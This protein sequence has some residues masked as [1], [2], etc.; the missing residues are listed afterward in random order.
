MGRIVVERVPEA[1]EAAVKAI[2]AGL[3]AFNRS[4]LGERVGEV[5]TVSVRSDDGLIV[6]GAVGEVGL[7]YLF[8]RYLWVDGELRGQDVG[9]RVLGMLE[10]EARRLGAARAYVDTFSFQA[11]GF[12]RKQ[13]YTEFGRLDDYPPGHSR[14]WMTKDL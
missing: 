3:L 7:G 13:G 2:H 12:Y 8:V 1:A 10:D 5:V 6:G 14:H 9:S 4:V 11:P